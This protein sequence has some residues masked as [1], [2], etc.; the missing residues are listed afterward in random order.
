MEGTHHHRLEHYDIKGLQYVF[1]FIVHS[2][3]IN[4]DAVYV[5]AYNWA[6]PCVYSVSSVTSENIVN[7]KHPQRST[8]SRKGQRQFPLQSLLS[9]S[10]TVQAR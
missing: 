4:Q 5:V 2:S 8:L 7:F 6:S 9:L 10:G 3:K 1:L